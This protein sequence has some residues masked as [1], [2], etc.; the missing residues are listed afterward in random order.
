MGYD[1]LLD[2]FDEIMSRY[3][4]LTDSDV[5]EA[6]SLMRDSSSLLASYDQLV[7]DAYKYSALAERDA[8]ATEARRSL[9][10]SPKPTEGARRASADAEVRGAWGRFIDM[11]TKQKYA[12]ANARFLN[13]VYFDSKMIVENGYRKERAPVGNDRIVGRL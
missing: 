8:K 4:V 10:L 13:R 2:Q 11:A 1:E 9:E 5:L 6:F 3:A 7:A 12:E